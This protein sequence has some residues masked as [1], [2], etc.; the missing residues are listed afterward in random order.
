ML[1]KNS[2]EKLMD[3]IVEQQ[4]FFKVKKLAIYAAENSFEIKN[5]KE[6]FEAMVSGGILDPKSCTLYKSKKYNVCRIE[7]LYLF[8]L[9]EKKLKEK[10]IEIINHPIRLSANVKAKILYKHLVKFHTEVLENREYVNDKA[11]SWLQPGHIKFP[12]RSD[13]DNGFKAYYNCSACLSRRYFLIRRCRTIIDIIAAK[14]M[15]KNVIDNAW[16]MYEVYCVMK[17]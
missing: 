8:N 3:K 16:S 7:C 2:I 15:D 10:L 14:E 13:I 11:N 12:K 4:R 17:G 6:I 1:L 9:P 5:L